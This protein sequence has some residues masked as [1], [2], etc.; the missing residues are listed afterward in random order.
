MADDSNTPK[1]KATKKKPTKKKVV[2][3][4]EALADGAHGGDLALVQEVHVDVDQVLDPHARRLEDGEDVVCVHAGPGVGESEDSLY[5]R[6]SVQQEHVTEHVELPS[7]H[8]EEHGGDHAKVLPRAVLDYQSPLSPL[9]RPGTGITRGGKCKN[10]E[11]N[12]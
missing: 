3:T 1:K 11:G 2:I 10:E 7:Q 5:A 4:E 8:G 12:N 9:E 6:G